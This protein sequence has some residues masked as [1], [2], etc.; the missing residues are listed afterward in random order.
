MV[1]ALRNATDAIDQ[2]RTTEPD[3]MAYIAIGTIVDGDDL[4]VRIADNG[5]GID[6]QIAEEAFDAFAT[7]KPANKGTGLGLFVCR[8]IIQEMGGS[9]TLGPNRLKRHGAILTVR[10]PA[11]SNPAA[12]EPVAMNSLSYVYIVD[13]DDV[14]RA[15]LGDALNRHGAVRCFSSGRALPA[16]PTDPKVCRAAGLRYAPSAPVSGGTGRWAK[17]RAAKVVCHCSPIGQA[18][19]ASVFGFSGTRHRSP[20][21]EKPFAISGHSGCDSSG[22]DQA[23]TKDR[24]DKNS[25]TPCGEGDAVFPA[26]AR[27]LERHDARPA[28]KKIAHELAIFV[29]TVETQ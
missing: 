18:R 6:A 26:R 9:I 21:V 5:A 17:R 29:R 20:A 4:L 16:E 8:Q 1:N 14:I 11:S 13:D 23:F 7:T 12:K 10:S 27:C 25:A 24:G 15:E 3:A 22:A 19:A 2:M 28:N